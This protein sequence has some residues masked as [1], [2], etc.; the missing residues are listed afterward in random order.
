[1]GWANCGEDSKGRPIGYAH[2]AT[3]DHPGCEKRIDRGLSYACGDMHGEDEVSCEGY[4]CPEHRRAWVKRP[5][6]RDVPICNACESLL[7]QSGD[8]VMDD[9]EGLLIHKD[10]IMAG[11]EE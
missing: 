8:Y 10:D 2:R 6:S 3:C 1:M 4:F 9:E 7:L 11:A 5:D